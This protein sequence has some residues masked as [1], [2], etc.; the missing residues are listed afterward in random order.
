MLQ[1]ATIFT[2]MIQEIQRSVAAEILEQHGI[3]AAIEQN[4]D[5]VDTATSLQSIEQWLKRKSGVRGQCLQKMMNAG[6]ADRQLLTDR[7]YTS[8]VQRAAGNALINSCTCSMEQ[9]LF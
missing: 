4:V 9:E 3:W 8:R 2:V 6:D 5:N 1:D 7:P